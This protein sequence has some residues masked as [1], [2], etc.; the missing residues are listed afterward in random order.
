MAAR[1]ATLSIPE[2]PARLFLLLIAVY[3]RTLSVV[4]G[5]RC[6]FWPSCSVYASE[7]LQ[8]YPLWTALK[9]ITGRLLRC[10]PFH[11]GGIDLP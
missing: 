2:P 4:L 10:H 5:P 1:D 11:P 8:R 3:R 7:S 6:R 9:K